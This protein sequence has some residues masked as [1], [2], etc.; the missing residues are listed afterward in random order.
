MSFLSNWVASAQESKHLLCLLNSSL[1]KFIWVTSAGSRPSASSEP[2]TIDPLAGCGDTQKKSTPIPFVVPVQF[3][4]QFHQQWLKKVEGG[5]FLPSTFSIVDEK[6]KSLQ[7]LCE[8]SSLPLKAKP[9]LGSPETGNESLSL[10]SHPNT[11]QISLAAAQCLQPLQL[12][13]GY[14][15]QEEYKRKSIYSRVVYIRGN[16]CFNTIPV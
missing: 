1:R 3:S 12:L 11:K 5:V 14:K 2:S 8:L 13:W 4:R 15:D 10:D 6:P 7:Q 9:V 16:W